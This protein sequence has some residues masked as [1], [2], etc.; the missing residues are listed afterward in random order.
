MT[1]TTPQFD[2]KALLAEARIGVL[3]TIK[4]D[5]RPQLSPITPTYDAEAGVV[6]VSMTEG[7]AKTVNLRR[8]PRATL[9]VTE[10]GRL[11]VG[12][13]RGHRRPSPARAPTR[14]APRSRRW[15][16]TTA[17]RPGSTPTG[18]STAPS[19]SPTGGC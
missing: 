19:W 13:G 4:S 15:S 7:R 6:R 5:G 2:P 1:Q 11:G 16:S 10:R 17:R 12:D 14:T 3:A 18:T 9:E 8:D